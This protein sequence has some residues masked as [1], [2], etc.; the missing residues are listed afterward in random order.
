MIKKAD[1]I[2]NKKFV[3]QMYINENL[4]DDLFI[5]IVANKYPNID[6]VIFGIGNRTIPSIYNEKYKNVH[7]S[8]KNNFIHKINIIFKILFRRDFLL[9]KELKKSDGLIILGGS[10]FID[11]L[12]H[13]ESMKANILADIRLHS[14]KI[15]KPTFI[16]GANFG[17]VYH[18][19]F[20]KKYKKFFQECKNVC[21]RDIKSKQLYSDLNNIEHA[22][23][24]IFNM[25]KT[26]MQIKEKTIG[27][28]IIDLSDS[29][30]QK[31]AKYK[32]TYEDKMIE[33][34]NDFIHL[35]Y[36]INMYSFC[37]NQGDNKAIERIKNKVLNKDKINCYEYK[38]METSNFLDNFTSNEYIISTRFHGMIIG[39]INEQKVYPIIYDIK[40]K[41]VIDEIG[42]EN[43]CSLDNIYAAKATDILKVKK[44]K[45]INK[46]QVN[47]HKQFESFEKYFNLNGAHLYEKNN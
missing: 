34:I 22:P 35:D 45:N 26:N 18:E 13:Y 32:Q 28:S 37:N 43:Y 16:I 10:V 21:Y 8:I 15:G 47:A 23:D 27:F 12:N 5:D 33:L 19:K 38:N 44:Q 2:P 24:V 20:I 41:N 29:S 42:I 6:F 7:V 40:T 17:P 4:G 25:N 1:N 31:I 11:G 36:E 46:I 9:E 14:Q 30:H 39:L 3:L